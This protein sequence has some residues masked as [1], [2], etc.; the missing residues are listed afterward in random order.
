MFR[1][2]D[3]IPFG[4]VA[5]YSVMGV[6]ITQYYGPLTWVSIL[7]SGIVTVSS[8][9]TYL[10]LKMMVAGYYNLQQILRRI[11]GPFMAFSG[12]FLLLLFLSVV[13]SIFGQSISYHSYY[14]QGVQLS[15]M[16]KGGEIILKEFDT[17]PAIFII[18]L[19]L[20][21]NLGSRINR[22]LLSLCNSILLL[23]FSIH[24]LRMTRKKIDPHLEETLS[25]SYF[26][27]LR[28]ALYLLFA[29]ASCPLFLVLLN[30]YQTTQLEWNYIVS[31]IFTLMTYVLPVLSIIYSQRIKH[32]IWYA[33]LPST[34]NF[35]LHQFPYVWCVLP[36]V[37]NMIIILVTLHWVNLLGQLLIVE[38]PVV[39]LMAIVSALLGTFIN[40]KVLM[41]TASLIILIVYIII[42][43]TAIM[44]PSLMNNP[45]LKCP[46]IYEENNK[47]NMTNAKLHQLYVKLKN[48]KS[49][50]ATN[51]SDTS[52]SFIADTS[53]GMSKN[54]VSSN[55]LKSDSNQVKIKDNQKKNEN[56]QVKT[57]NNK[58][59]SNNEYSKKNDNNNNILKNIVTDEEKSETNRNDNYNIY[60]TECNCK[61]NMIENS[62]AI[63]CKCTNDFR[64]FCQRYQNNH[65]RNKNKYK[66]F[67]N[68]NQHNFSSDSSDYSMPQLKCHFGGRQ[69]L[70]LF[71][72]LTYSVTVFLAFRYGYLLY[73]ITTKYGMVAFIAVLGLI[74]I[75]CTLPFITNQCSTANIIL[76]NPMFVIIT[77]MFALTFQMMLL[78]FLSAELLLI[79]P[80]LFGSTIISYLMLTAPFIQEINADLLLENNDY[81]G[82]HSNNLIEEIG[83][84]MSEVFKRVSR[85]QIKSPEKLKKPKKESIIEKPKIPN[86]TSKSFNTMSEVAGGESADYNVSSYQRRT[87]QFSEIEV[88]K[89]SIKSELELKYSIPDVITHQSNEV[90]SIQT[91]NVGKVNVVPYITPHYT[92]VISATRNSLKKK[93]SKKLKSIQSNEKALNKLIMVK[94]LQ[95]KDRYII[96]DL[97]S[98]QKDQQYVLIKQLQSENDYKMEE[99]DLDKLEYLKRESGGKKIIQLKKL[100]DQQEREQKTVLSYMKTKMKLKEEE[101]TTELYEKERELKLM[102]SQYG[103]EKTQQTESTTTNY[104]QS[105]YQ[106]NNKRSLTNDKLAME[107]KLIKVE[108]ELEKQRS[109]YEETLIRKQNELLEKQEKLLTYVSGQKT[110]PESSNSNFY[111]K[112]RPNLKSIKDDYLNE[113]GQMTNERSIQRSSENSNKSIETIYNTK[114]NGRYDTSNGYSRKARTQLL[115]R[116]AEELTIPDES[117][118]EV[119]AAEIQEKIEA[120]LT[121]RLMDHIKHYDGYMNY[122]KFY[123]IYDNSRKS[124]FDGHP[125]RKTIRIPRNS[126]KKYEISKS[127]THHTT[128][129]KYAIKKSL[130]K[131]F[132]N[133]P[134]HFENSASTLHNVSSYHS[135][136]NDPNFSQDTS[137]TLSDLDFMNAPSRNEGKY[138]SS[139]IQSFDN[140]NRHVPLNNGSFQNDTKND[141]SSSMVSSQGQSTQ[142]NFVANNF[143]HANRPSYPK[144]KKN[145]SDFSND[146]PIKSAQSGSIHKLSLKNMMDNEKHTRPSRKRSTFTARPFNENKSGYY[147][148]QVFPKSNYSNDSLVEYNANNPIDELDSLQQPT[149]SASFAEDIIHRNLNDDY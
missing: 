76:I 97:I 10:H 4:T 140:Q 39:A 74:C 83:R 111:S 73:D 25:H 41:E 26:G 85:Q 34:L 2:A 100:L 35:P 22:T 30:R 11:Y 18:P 75:C 87:R 7:I 6:L 102:R 133:S 147:I 107:E 27:V 106:T 61:D 136:K 96:G 95:E 9:V 123:E 117:I 104:I 14:A 82:D 98:E 21:S 70:L 45:N 12:T 89:E 29:F 78:A 120:T 64:L 92:N 124:N 49:V 37:M 119:L 118:E 52:T 128:D 47:E 127:L 81:W 16:L 88:Q 116:Y 19:A 126:L 91:E 101:L 129:N 13:V 15:E 110:N 113:D 33:L 134:V 66:T 137:K 56:N 54:K 63:C 122:E 84:L 1:S 51:T 46:C 60:R 31:Y 48:L 77:P 132:E 62:E 42:T 139:N 68:V 17:T 94:E 131:N 24:L 108:K 55:Q 57:E 105:E 103:T 149:S 69:I 3:F 138:S 144:S 114:L 142:F 59:N 38:G 23:S 40:P 80:I 44:F 135:N 79:L 145:E 65:W 141:Q 109:L 53:D 50:N 93:I 5:F 72:L 8:C 32:C 90:V 121:A 58:K 148:E 71:F 146:F 143:P 115:P 43:F 86:K 130:S 20:V 112:K 99:G 67:G 36:I 125:R 28:G